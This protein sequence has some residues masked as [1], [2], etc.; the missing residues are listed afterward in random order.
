MHKP[1]TLCFGQQKAISMSAL[2]PPNI[3]SELSYAYLHAVA[4]VARMA[5]AEAHRHEDN[6]GIDAR[7]VSWGPFEEG[8]FTEAYLNVQLKATAVTPAEEGDRF[9]Y[10]L[11]GVARY[12]KLR[13]EPRMIPR[14]LVV[15]FLPEDADSWLNHTEERLALRRCA[16]RTSLLGAPETE[17]T[18]GET[19]YIPKANIFSAESLTVLMNRVARRERIVYAG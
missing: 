14:I 12:N 2:S 17:N 16:Y 10:F 7:L 4:S 19:V 11:Q 1:D 5:C 8:Y 9:S 3:E 6:S 13:E 18:T 15:M